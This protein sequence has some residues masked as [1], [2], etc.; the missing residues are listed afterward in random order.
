MPSGV[1]RGARE[2]TLRMQV[3]EREG[4]W[5]TKRFKEKRV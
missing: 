5:Q 4:G 3:G 1:G 2:Y